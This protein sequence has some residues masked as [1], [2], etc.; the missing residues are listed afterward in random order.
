MVSGWLF[1]FS[2]RATNE[3]ALPVRVTSLL[4]THEMLTPTAQ[5]IVLLYS[6]IV[7]CLRTACERM[8]VEDCTSHPSMCSCM[9]SGILPVVYCVYLCS[10]GSY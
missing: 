2:G 4:G 3:Y 5:G 8:L 7:A 6:M 10:V 1:V 9:I